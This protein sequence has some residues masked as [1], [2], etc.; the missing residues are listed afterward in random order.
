MAD[1]SDAEVARAQAELDNAYLT[2]QLVSQKLAG[3][4]VD[5]ALRLVSQSEYDAASA[6]YVRC[7]VN[8][9][10]ARA[11]QAQRALSAT[12]APAP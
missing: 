4:P 10:E 11:T 7:Y 8:M 9:R 5:T 3:V 2:V 6:W 1:W 12:P